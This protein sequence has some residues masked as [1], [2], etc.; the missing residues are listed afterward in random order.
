MG[1]YQVIV[2]ANDGAGGSA[3]VAVNIEITQPNNP[4]VLPDTTLELSVDSDETN[5]GEPVSATDADAGDTITYS[6]GGEDL[7]H[8]RVDPSTGQ[9]TRASETTAGSYAITV[10][11]TDGAGAADSV[12]VTIA[13]IQRTV[14]RCFPTVRRWHGQ[15][16]WARRM[17]GCR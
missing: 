5:V 14:R 8:F 2:D 9:I 3:S 13:V 15:R 7:T 12:E 6:L 17:S 16:G 1:T 11:A 10:T 4:P